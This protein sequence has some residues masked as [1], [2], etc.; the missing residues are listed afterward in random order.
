MKLESLDKLF[1]SSIIFCVVSI[2]ILLIYHRIKYYKSNYGKF[3]YYLTGESNISGELILADL[4]FQGA[5]YIGIVFLFGY[6]TQLI[7][8]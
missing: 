6:F 7:I 3:E 2:F 5:F 1:I 8:F 4:I